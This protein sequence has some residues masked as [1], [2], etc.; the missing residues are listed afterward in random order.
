[1]AAD[2]AWLRALVEGTLSDRQNDLLGRLQEL[3]QRHAR[4]GLRVE[5]NAQQLL[6]SGEARACLPDAVS[7]AVTEAVGE[8]LTNTAKHACTDTAVLCAVLTEEALVVSVLDHGVGFDAGCTRQGV[9][10][11]HSIHGR[12]AE[13]GGHVQ[14]DSSHGEGTYVEITVQSAAWHPG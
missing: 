7:E 2:A 3:V 5:F 8:A 13:I 10:L 4:T 11:R 14:V 6:R 1:V 12:I 9:G